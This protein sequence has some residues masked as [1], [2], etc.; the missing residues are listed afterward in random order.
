MLSV[1]V[2]AYNEEKM[3]QKS[4]IVIGRLLCQESIEYEIIFINDGSDDGTWKEIRSLCRQSPIVKGISFSRNF[5]KEAAIFAGME[6]AKGDC[7]VMIDCDLQHP[8][9][10]ILDMYRLWK[11]GYEVVEGVK[12]DRGKESLLYKVAAKV[13]YHMISNA[14][15][16]DMRKASDFKL[17][18]RKVMDTLLAMP[19][20]QV[21]FRALSAWVGFK[22]TKVA[23]QVQER[24][25]GKTKWSAASLI[26][27]ALNN[28]SSY[29]SAPMQAVTIVG[30]MFLL[31]SVVFGIQTLVLYGKGK[32]L[33]GFTTV[34]IL[35]LLIGSILMIS[36]GVI[37]YY[38][39]K[40]YNEIKGRPRYIVAQSLN[41]KKEAKEDMRVENKA[42]TDL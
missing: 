31:F 41:N 17:L 39:S 37:G 9:E 6:Y 42:G 15:G 35:L 25:V 29:S 19:E 32:A 2:P 18:D 7:C 24:E 12:S 4:S 11:E 21:F 20:K 5:G 28:I 23:F 22:S 38:I 40:I 1:I 3:I 8:P 13:F 27:Y 14:T 16:I 34:I 26:K 30:V 10:V 36:L 33:E